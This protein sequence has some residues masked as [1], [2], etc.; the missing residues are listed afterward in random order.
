VPG[1]RP[2]LIAEY[3]LCAMTGDATDLESIFT[4]DVRGWN[5]TGRTE[6]LQDM[7]DTCNRRRDTFSD[8]SMRVNSL[9]VA[10][11]RA[12]CEWKLKAVHSGLLLTSN[13]RRIDPRGETLE[14]PG[15]TVAE[16]RG[17]RISAFRTYF[18]LMS[19]VE[20]LIVPF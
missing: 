14:L 16:F 12:T 3:L 19:I 9:S 15:V 13:Q 18:D 2:D 4:G 7:C 20:Q 10:G 6:S 8:V 1:V 17:G 5:P 11:E